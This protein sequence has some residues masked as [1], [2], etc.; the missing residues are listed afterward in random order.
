MKDQ[1]SEKNSNN[2]FIVR[3]T[4]APFRHRKIEMIPDGKQKTE[5]KVVYLQD[6]Q[7]NSECDLTSCYA[8]WDNF[9]FLKGPS[10]R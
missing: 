8:N 6:F 7:K 10:L 2:P 5:L 9:T 3:Y 1:S 4:S